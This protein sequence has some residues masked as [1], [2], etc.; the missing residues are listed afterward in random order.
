MTTPTSTPPKTRQPSILRTPITPLS[1]PWWI[2][3]AGG[4]CIVLLSFFADDLVL[5]GLGLIEALFLCG[6]LVQ[7]Y[8]TKYPA[9]AINWPLMVFLTG[10]AVAIGVAWWYFTWIGALVVFGGAVAFFGHPQSLLFFVV[11]GRQ[12]N[13]RATQARIKAARQERDATYEPKRLL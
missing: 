13:A 2:M 4:S 11:A 7:A 10:T 12:A 8:Q 6:L 1:K 5:R 9:N 3:I